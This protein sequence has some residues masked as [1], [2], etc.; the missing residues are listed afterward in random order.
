M[1]DTEKQARDDEQEI[2]DEEMESVSGGIIDGG[3]IIFPPILKPTIQQ[4]QLTENL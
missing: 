4:N 3:C 2:S 1:S